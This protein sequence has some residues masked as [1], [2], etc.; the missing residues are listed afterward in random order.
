M[1][2]LQGKSPAI[3]A[4]PPILTQQQVEVRSEGEMVAIQ[5]GNSTLRMHYK[6]AI[7][8]SQWIRV[9]VKECKRFVGDTSHHWS[10]MAELEGIPKL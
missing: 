4:K 5:V 8:L 3:H 9:R 2:H 6:D 1:Q 10:A 7:Q